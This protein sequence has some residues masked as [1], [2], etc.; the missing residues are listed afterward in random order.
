MAT[1]LPIFVSHSHEDSA[2]CR[3]LVDAL[4]GAGADVWY[5]EHNLESGQLLD[6]IQRELGRRKIFILILSKH[7]F[8]SKWVRRE[9]GWA[10]NL[11][12][13]D[14]TRVILP[15]TAG[16][17]ERDDFSPEQGWLFLEDF[18][19]IEAPGLKPFPVGEAV[20]RVLHA[21][22]L[23]PAG[24]APVTAAPQPTESA[25]D[26]ITRGKAL[27]QQGKHAE[28]LALFERATQLNPRSYSAWF[29]V[30]FSLDALGRYEQG[31]AAY[32]R[33]ISL[34]RNDAGAW[35][36]KGKALKSLQRYSEA[37][38]AFEQALAL[39][40][41]YVYAWNGKGNALDDLGR[42]QE[43]LSAYE[44]ALAVDPNFWMTWKNMALTLRR[45]GRA[46]EAEQAEARA[47]ALG[48]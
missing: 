39:D 25:D 21:L 43:A 38:A 37:L 10:Y 30:G 18:K 48:G 11:F 44:Q 7:A 42:S 35:N 2:F 27:Q 45:L 41:K 17:I 20:G 36:N 34:N 6:V 29:N 16:A 47:K 14:P 28:A 8:G 12:D 32:D 1:A 4:R 40:P 46:Q 24:T 23:T 26:L 15:V 9:T 31:I 22:A 33:A 5:D 13:R 3:A 19:R